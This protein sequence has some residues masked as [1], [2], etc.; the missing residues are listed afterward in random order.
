MLACNQRKRDEPQGRQARASASRTGRS[1]PSRWCE[2]TRTARGTG[3]NP[4]RRRTRQRGHREADSSIRYDGGAIFGQPQE[5]K[6]GGGTPNGRDARRDGKA[7]VKVRRVRAILFT[8]DTLPGRRDLEDPAERRRSR[9]GAVEAIHR[10]SDRVLLHE[11]RETHRKVSFDPED[12]TNP[13]PAR[14]VTAP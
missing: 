14:S 12:Q 10:G 6:F 2:T 13:I 4:P 5:R 9:R 11:R 3:G 8:Q 1:K 7:G